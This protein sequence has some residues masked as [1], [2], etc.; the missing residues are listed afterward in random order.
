MHFQ[1][2]Y[3]IIDAKEIAMYN[4]QRYTFERGLFMYCTNCGGKMEKSEKFCSI[5][6]SP[7][8]E[9][10]TGGVSRTVVGILYAIAS[11]LLIFIPKLS[12]II[13][14]D[15]SKML[16]SIMKKDYG[17]VSDAVGGFVILLNALSSYDSIVYPTAGLLMAVAALAL[18]LKRRG[19]YKAATISGIAGFAALAYS[20]FMLIAVPA[21]PKALV[22]LFIADKDQLDIA[23][24]IARSEPYFVIRYITAAVLLAMVVIPAFILMTKSRNKDKED[25]VL[26]GKLERS[27][28]SLMTLLPLISI[29]LVLKGS[30]STIYTATMGSNALMAYNAA[31]YTAANFVS[32]S[33]FALII[34][35]AYCMI[36]KKFSYPL[37]I[38]PGLGA[39][40]LY[41]I[42]AVA[43]CSVVLNKEGLLTAVSPEAYEMAYQAVLPKVMGTIFLLAAIYFWIAATARGNVR[44]WGQIIFAVSFVL[45]CAVSERMRVSGFALGIEVPFTEIVLG[46]L[47][48]SAAIPMSIRNRE[49]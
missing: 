11:L 43:S 2:I 14:G 10:K 1:C 5:C 35:T 31:E 4:Q 47:I 18:L 19:A 6:G 40:L 24:R 16:E 13:M 28:A 42:I 12:S 29:S 15:T 21:F 36:M 38:L 22:S 39:I 46:I 34:I 3:G 25:T 8:K 9:E 23:V 7:A 44:A 41:G 45:L 27:T 37:F 20:V 17:N 48:L 30:I 49:K 32:I 26:F 33:L